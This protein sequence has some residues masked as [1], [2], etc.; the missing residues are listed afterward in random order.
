MDLG[1]PLASEA[2]GLAEEAEKVAAVVGSGPLL[3]WVEWVQ[4]RRH[5][6]RESQEALGHRPRLNRS[7]P[8]AL[9][10]LLEASAALAVVV[11]V[12]LAARQSAPSVPL[13]LLRWRW[14]RSPSVQL[15][16]VAPLK[17]LASARAAWA[18]Q[19]AHLMQSLLALPHR[20]KSRNLGARCGWLQSSG[21]S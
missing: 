3:Q 9:A 12:A 7:R 4:Q 20:L 16:L 15:A 21:P 17:D 8:G 14:A 6:G 18:V 1:A 5:R 2:W 11:V 10:H 13:L 19:L